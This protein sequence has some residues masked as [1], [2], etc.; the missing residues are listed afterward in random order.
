MSKRRRMLVPISVRAALQRINRKLAPELR[1]VRKCPP[2]SRG[3]RELGRYYHVDMSSNMVT[4]T[5]IDLTDFGQELG[6]L[7][8]WETVVDK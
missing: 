2:K 4:I 8:E 6:V 3:F 7:A 1:A 5:H